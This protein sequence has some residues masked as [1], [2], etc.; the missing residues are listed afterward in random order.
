VLSALLIFIIKIYY[1]NQIASPY[2]MNTRRPTHKVPAC[3][4]SAILFTSLAPLAH[5]TVIVEN[6]VFTLS[7]HTQLSETLNGVVINDYTWDSGGGGF[8]WNSAEG[9]V[10]VP[11]GNLLFAD[12]LISGGYLEIQSYAYGAFE[13][14]NYAEALSAEGGDAGRVPV[15]PP[16]TID[17][18]QSGAT[19]L[20]PNGVV[21]VNITV[22]GPNSVPD[23]TPT[24]G[25]LFI[26]CVA[27]FVAR[28]QFSAA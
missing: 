20:T 2:V 13:W 5:G 9:G 14:A 10:T 1:E 16:S 11:S 8:F 25:L 12:P 21:D 27:L 7:S 3:I 19:V 24:I 23:A 18:S 22:T 17:F 26:A 4:L 15:P 28:R 6:L